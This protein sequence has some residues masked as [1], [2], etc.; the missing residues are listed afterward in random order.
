MNSGLIRVNRAIRPHGN[1]RP[2]AE[3]TI[4]T[5]LSHTSVQL[6]GICRVPAARPAC[7][8]SVHTVA[9]DASTNV[10][11][12]AIPTNE[13]SSIIAL[14]SSINSTTPR[15]THISVYDDA[16]SNQHGSVSSPTL[17]HPQHCFIEQPS[18]QTRFHSS[19]RRASATNAKPY[20]R[21]NH[22]RHATRQASPRLSDG[23][24]Q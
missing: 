12:S 5:Y 21:T 20:S 3:A 4:P 23:R 14:P 7:A 13:F 8:R 17:T 22:A 24:R 2:N 10:C 9:P 6:S 11:L 15:A 18:Y 19:A 16:S 1:R